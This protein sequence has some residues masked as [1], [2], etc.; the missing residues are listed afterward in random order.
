[1]S[2][3][4]KLIQKLINRTLRKSELETLLIRLGFSRFR[5]KGSHA[6]WGRK[7]IA[8]LHIVI[9]THSKEVPFYQLKQIEISLKKRS[10]I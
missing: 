8:D 9:A 2:S 5:G 4:E 10:L 6:V 1:M 3:T 7:D